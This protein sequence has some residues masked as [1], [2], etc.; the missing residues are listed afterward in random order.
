MGKPLFNLLTDYNAKHPL[1][2]HVICRH[3]GACARP[4]VKTTT[5]EASNVI[6]GKRTLTFQI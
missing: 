1:E 2:A 4:I 3:L 5:N 6:G